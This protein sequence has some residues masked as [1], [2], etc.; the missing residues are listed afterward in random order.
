MIIISFTID[1]NGTLRTDGQIDYEISTE[2]TVRI[3]TTDPHGAFFEQDFLIEVKDLD[4]DVPVL[5]LLG[6]PNMTHGVGLTFYDPDFEGRT[7]RTAAV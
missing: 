4:E 7:H 1:E 5:T 6:E 3:R 2:L